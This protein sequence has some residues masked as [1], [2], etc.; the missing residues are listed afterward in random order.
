MEKT[1]NRRSLVSMVNSL[2]KNILIECYKVAYNGFMGIMSTLKQV[3][4]NFWWAKLRDDVKIYVNNCDVWQHN[5]AS[6]IRI[7][8]LL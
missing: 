1:G 8:G 2:H 6:T 7:A 3:E 4:R 5:K